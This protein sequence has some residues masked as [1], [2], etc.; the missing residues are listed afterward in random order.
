MQKI[1]VI[2]YK[3][4]K[5]TPFFG[6]LFVSVCQKAI[7]LSGKCLFTRPVLCMSGIGFENPVPFGLQRCLLF[8]DL[9]G[10]VPVGSR[11]TADSFAEL[12]VEIAQVIEATAECDLG[13]GQ[14]SRQK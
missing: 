3:P 14:I 7:R 4:I 13:N 10:F 5:K 9:A 1:T 2:K 12:T 11:R 6:A 8:A